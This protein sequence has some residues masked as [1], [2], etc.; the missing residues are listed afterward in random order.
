MSGEI[1]G[2]K[3]GFKKIAKF[4]K[5]DWDFLHKTSTKYEHTLL[6]NKE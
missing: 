1:N 2:L 5:W 4:L 3:A 6:L